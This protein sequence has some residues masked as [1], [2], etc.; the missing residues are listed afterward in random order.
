VIDSLAVYKDAEGELEVERLSNLSEDE[1]IELGTKI[2]SAQQEGDERCADAGETLESRRGGFHAHSRVDCL[3]ECET[4]DQSEL[5]VTVKRHPGPSL[6][7]E[8][9]QTHSP[10]VLSAVH[11]VCGRGT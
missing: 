9:W 10:D 2:W 6:G 7:R 4:A 8:S 3:H 1:A 11:N 5:G